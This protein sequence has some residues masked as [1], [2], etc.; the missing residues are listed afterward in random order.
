M[1]DSQ[2]RLHRALS[3]L[4]CPGLRSE[5]TFH[6]GSGKGIVVYPA[7]KKKARY[8]AQLALEWA[9]R[10]DVGGYLEVSSDIPPGWGLG[11]S[12][13]DVTAALRAVFS[14]LELQ[15]EDRVVARLAVKAETACDSSIF[16]QS[17]VLFAH[18]EGEVLEEFGG[19]MPEC[20]VLG[21]NTDEEGDGVDTLEF[22]PARYG[23]Q[24]IDTFAELIVLL[25]RAIREQD[26]RLLGQVSSTCARINQA[27]LPKPHFEQL[28][29][30]VERV[31]SVGLQVAHSG[32]V[33]GLLFDP[34]DAEMNSRLERAREELARLGFSKTWRFSTTQVEPL[35]FED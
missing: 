22:S 9:G 25:R 8:A 13:S 11:S 33:V 34:R 27:Y 4:P 28:E 30:V 32:T 12:T 6:V 26:V 23:A 19:P 15:V 21:F 14:S 16:D 18:R 2:G 31:G 1:R 17:A 7:W 5:A 20:E 35:R 24:E 29:A 3:S 10:T